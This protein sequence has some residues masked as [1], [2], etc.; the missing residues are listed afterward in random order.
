MGATNGQGRNGMAADVAR[1]LAS[2]R[3]ADDAGGE[4]D[5][6]AFPLPNEPRR[7][8]V[9]TAVVEPK[10]ESADLGGI[11]PQETADAAWTRF[12]TPVDVPE[13]S[14]ETMPAPAAAAASAVVVA[15]PAAGGGGGD[16]GGGSGTGN[17]GNDGGG[18]P[19]RQRLFQIVDRPMSIFEHLDEL[20]RRLMWSVLAFVLGMSLTFP[21]IQQLLDATIHKFH[22]H[23]IAIG[24]MESM[25]GGM[26]IMV[27][28]GIALASP[29]ILY[30]IIAF[31]VPA[32]TGRERRMLWGY[33]PASV[34]LFLAG[35]A[36]GYELFEPMAFQVSIH[37]LKN[38]INTPSLSKWVDFL[39]AYSLPFGGVFEM[40]VV[41]AIL[42]KLG[43][44]SPSL[45]IKN[46]RWALV[47]CVVLALAVSPPDTLF[48]T[49]AMVAVPLIALYEGSI[50][51]SRIAYRQVLRDR[52]RQE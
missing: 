17:G 34:V 30:Q 27:I 46:Q 25:F 8:A 10:F 9:A 7:S 41:A 52:E 50:V 33:L 26:R 13:P 22:V 6:E 51:V 47:G 20:R 4:D 21:F 48:F 42:T 3:P 29:V 45:L 31:I 24:P 40:P 1:L 2:A 5:L 35:L 32:M 37:F 11:I 19:G 23:I 18:G 49:P 39:T 28:G 16:S 44:I 12:R 15:P 36:F 43:I 14:E 38:V